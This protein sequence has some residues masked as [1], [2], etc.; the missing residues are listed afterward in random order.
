MYGKCDYYDITP[1]AENKNYIRFWKEGKKTL[2][3]WFVP[4]EQNVL[5]F[6]T[7][8]SVFEYP[9]Y[10]YARKIGYKK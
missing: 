9:F 6:A 10:A 5:I 7:V 8:L 1:L 2:N 4:E 3:E